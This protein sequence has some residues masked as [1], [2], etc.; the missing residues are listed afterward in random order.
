LLQRAFSRQTDPA[1]K[2]ERWFAGIHNSS[3]RL[4][5]LINDLAEYSRLGG[6]AR[7][8]EP[9][10][11]GILL[12]AILRDFDGR[13][14]ELGAKIEVSPL[15]VLMCDGIQMRQVLQN[16]IANALKYRHPDRAPVVRISADA[17]SNARVQRQQGLPVITLRVEDNGIGFDERHRERI[18][19]PFE[20]LH[21]SDKYEG[22]G[23]GLAICRKVVDRHGGTIT[24]HGQ[25]G[26]GAVFIITLPL[27]PHPEQKTSIA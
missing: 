15:P 17:Q 9:V 6:Q 1:E 18:F 8:F 26:A 27:R 24:A 21:S 10:D 11:F 19:E 12:A 25:P 3:R 5:Q 4:R 20:R 13:I 22:T 7:P 16:L 2:I 14:E 23:L